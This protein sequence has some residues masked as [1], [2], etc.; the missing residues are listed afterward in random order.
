MNETENIL[1]VKNFIKHY[2][3]EIARRL[4]RNDYGFYGDVKDTFVPTNPLP[5]IVD[6]LIE[7]K[8][9][10][11]IS[12]F[13]QKQD[14]SGLKFS[15]NGIFALSDFT[16]MDVDTFDPVYPMYDRD[17]FNEIVTGLVKTLTV[18]KTVLSP[19]MTKYRLT[20]QEYIQKSMT[21]MFDID[22]EEEYMVYRYL[23]SLIQDKG[24]LEEYGVSPTVINNPRAYNPVFDYSY[25]KDNED[26]TVVIEDLKNEIPDFTHHIDE[27]MKIM[28]LPTDQM[29][30]GKITTLSYMDI[31]TLVL[32]FIGYYNKAKELNNQPSSDTGLNQILF[33]MSSVI[34][35][36]KWILKNFREMADNNTIFVGYKFYG[37]NKYKVYVIKENFDKVV[38]G[39]G[40]VNQLYGAM[41]KDI[42]K[43][44]DHK[45]VEDTPYY[46][47]I[48]VNDF[49]LEKSS[50]EKAYRH[51]LEVLTL[52][53]R[54]QDRASLI[55]IY[56]V[57][58]KFI[59]IDDFFKYTKYSDKMKVM[60]LVYSYVS[61]KSIGEL[62]DVP[63][64]VV[65]IFKDC[66]FAS[67]SFSYFLNEME[68]SKKILGENTDANM[69]A[70]YAAL[71]LLAT[72]LI[73]QLDVV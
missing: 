45:L 70:Y 38:E 60:E 72:Y 69:A 54:Q 28:S 67:N 62:S 53:S 8:L 73:E 44:Q 3:L 33:L 24:L 13:Y 71:S 11:Y 10:E 64:M 17:I 31:D 1:R 43:N 35:R 42:S 63:S 40:T 52:K 66:L 23:Y 56:S 9:N 58:I 41:L 59:S 6:V 14:I 36:L 57:S 4:A 18:F 65:S 12:K 19:S 48:S 15:R 55:D 25:L 46:S 16:K 49:L 37:E 32:I 29:V 47:Y 2:M 22:G 51:Y 39:G 27:A 68:S 30:Y 61:N 26:V 50:Y 34:K 20:V 21:S 5:D 7:D